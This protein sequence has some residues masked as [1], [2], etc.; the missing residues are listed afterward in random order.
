MFRD[1]WSTESISSAVPPVDDPNVRWKDVE[2]QPDRSTALQAPIKDLQSK[3]SKHWSNGEVI[4]R[5]WP[6][7]N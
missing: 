4:R 3:I 1:T 5:R 2:H 7:G 6:N